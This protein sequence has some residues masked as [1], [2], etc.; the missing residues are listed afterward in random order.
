MSTNL[1]K[2]ASEILGK[3]IAPRLKKISHDL[4][5]GNTS[6]GYYGRYRVAARG[7]NSICGDAWRRKGSKLESDKFWWKICERTVKDALAVEYPNASVPWARVRGYGKEE[8]NLL[9]DLRIKKEG[10]KIKR[11]GNASI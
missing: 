11:E 3:K 4:K 5:Y 7:F 8:A 2:L 9:C 1:N 10:R 6:N